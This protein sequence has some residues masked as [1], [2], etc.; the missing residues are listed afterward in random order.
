MD[1]IRNRHLFF[2][3]VILILLAAYASFA[4]RLDR[5]DLGDF[6]LGMI[7]FGALNAALIPLVFKFSG[8]YARYWHY[9]SI[10]E[11]LLLSATAV[12]GG[13]SASVLALGVASLHIASI[14][15]P[16]S[17]PFIFL[18]LAV[19]FTGLPR[20]GL[21][22]CHAYLQTNARGRVKSKPVA[23]MGAG[24]A[25]G[26]IV[27]ELQR[28][29]QLGMYAAVFFDDDPAKQNM[30]IYGVRVVGNRH[31]IPRAAAAYK[32]EQV[33]IAMPTAPGREI[34]EIVRICEEAGLKTKTMPGIY[35]LI[36]GKI[37][38]NQLRDV[39]IEDLLRREPIRTDTAAVEELIAGKTVLISGGGGS[40]GG[41]LSRQIWRCGPAHLI[42]LGHGENSIFEI[43]GELKTKVESF[44][45]NG[46][47]QRSGPPKLTPVIADIR[48]SEHIDSIIADYKPD[49]IFHAAAHKH[50]PLMEANP[51]EA[52]TNNVLGTRNLI[53]ASLSAGVE[54][55]VLISTDKAVNPTSIMGASKRVAE[56][57]VHQAARRSGRAYVAVRFGN[58]LGSR[59]SVIHT[60]KRQIA[61]GGPITITHPEMKR[62]FMTIPEAVQLVLQ[63]SVLGKG[64]EVFV[65]DMGEPVKIVDLAKD[66]IRLSGLEVG[67]DIEIKFIGMRP[68]EK[69]YEELFVAGEE[70]SRTKHEK[71]FIASNASSFVPEFLD[72]TLVSL[73][74]AAQRRDREAIIHLLQTLVPEY[75]PAGQTGV[76]DK[77]A[78]VPAKAPV[79]V[80]SR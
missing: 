20:L 22:F 49:I 5:L 18:P 24:D 4:L 14:Y 60:F 74:M 64:G 47:D 76:V 75:K 66:L 31:A 19:L 2:I 42:L 79:M 71:I 56:L 53:E 57:L 62:Y 44:S 48:F 32:I 46:Y 13:L 26:M 63:A 21:R 3:D 51:E 39:E 54:H 68:G 29:P 35:D 23:I 1:K 6:W 59:G 38:V 72:L 41:E 69:L 55:F 67:E 7:V 73:E 9:A 34:R 36:G 33:I 30:Y 52:I 27:R 17:T 12:I 61:N 70:Y 45:R 28:N 43:Y 37:S 15:I 78:P 40:I 11:L 77:A 8:I 65:L 16:R 80:L 50:V 10:D 58:V 25:G